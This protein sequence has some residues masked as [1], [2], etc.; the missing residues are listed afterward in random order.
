[1]SGERPGEMRIGERARGAP[2]IGA[3]ARPAPTV[4]DRTKIRAQVPARARGRATGTICRA[5]PTRR[6]FCAAT[7]SSSASTP[8]RSSTSTAA[9]SRS[10]RR[11]L[12][13][14]AAATGCSRGAGDSARGDRAPAAALW[15]LGGCSCSCVVLAVIVVA[16]IA[17]RRRH[18]PAT[19]TRA[20]RARHGR[21]Q[22]RSRQRPRRRRRRGTV[23]LALRGPRP[24]RGV[25]GRGRRARR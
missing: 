19:P 23:E 17:E 24:G 20:R 6:D 5:A 9:R 25:P 15:A 14:P 4:E 3:V 18:E 21:G 16:A 2:A 11:A 8:R 22:G 12:D 1:M 10:S 7:P 13:A